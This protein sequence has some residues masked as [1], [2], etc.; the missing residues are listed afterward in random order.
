[1]KFFILGGLPGSGKSTYAK[2]LKQREHCFVVCPDAIRRAL[3]AGIYPRN[4]DYQ[5]LEPLVWSLAEEAVTALLRQGHNV[6]IDGT[7]LYKASRRRWIDLARSINSDGQLSR[8]SGVPAH[9]ILRNAGPA[10]GGIA[11]KNIGESAGIWKPLSSSQRLRKELF[12]SC[13]RIATEDTEYTGREG[14]KRTRCFTLSPFH[15]F[16]LSPSL[17]LTLS[18]LCTLCALCG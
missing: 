9:G 18:P 15:P 4:S 2:A 13:K 6:A 14:K 12:S 7:H 3:N 8:L 16:T 1:M 17:P 10:N 11:R 5:V